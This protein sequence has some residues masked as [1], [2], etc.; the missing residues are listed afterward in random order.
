MRLTCIF[1]LL[2]TLSISKL[3]GQCSPGGNLNVPGSPDL[4]I[5]SSACYSSITMA[6]NGLLIV[7]SGATLTI[8]GN[9]NAENGDGI[10]VQNGGNLIIT[11]TLATNNNFSLQVFGTSTIGSIDVFNNAIFSIAGTGSINVTGNV[12]ADNNCSISVSLGG[13]F[14]VG[15]NVTV[16]GGNSS[17]NVNGTFHIDGQ[18]TGPTPSGSGNMDDLDQI[19]LPIYLP[20]TLKE[21]KLI[22]HPLGKTLFWSTVSE[23]NSS[24]FSMMKSNDGVN[25]ALVGNVSAAGTSNQEIQYEFRDTENSEDQGYYQLIQ[26]DFNG[27]YVDLGVLSNNCLKDITFNTYPNPSEQLFSIEIEGIDKNSEGNYY[28][29]L[30]DL[31]GRTIFSKSLNLNVGDYAIPIEIS[32]LITGAYI[33]KLTKENVSIR[34]LRHYIK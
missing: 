17:V 4:Y 8:N 25:W 26:Y 31:S 5:S 27:Q 34:S 7:Q 24:H 13:V 14:D 33:I 1:I 10:T 16:G 29:N 30:E 9:V 21:I 15:G 2:L 23:H 6:N 20:V 12:Q 32:G 11:G 22:C 28:L 3:F 19:F 18:Y